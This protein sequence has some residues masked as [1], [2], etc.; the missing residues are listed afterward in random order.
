MQKVKGRPWSFIIEF[1]EVKAKENG[2]DLETLYDYVERNVK[3][4]GVTRIAHGTWKA[5]EGNEVESQCLALSLLSN[6]KWVMQNIQ[7][8]IA[9]EDDT[10][11]IDCLDVFRKTDPQCLLV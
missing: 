5:K 2:Y 9:F 3:K 8:L 7:S 4:Y 1:D 6:A 11:A 10:D